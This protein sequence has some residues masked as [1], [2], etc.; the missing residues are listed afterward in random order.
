MILIS[1]LWDRE[2]MPWQADWY[3]Q[4]IDQNFGASADQH[5][6]LWYTDY[7]QHGDEYAIEDPTRTVSYGGELQEALRALAAWVEQGTPPPAST[8]YRIA[9]GQVIIPPTAA[10]RKGIQPVVDLQVNG[11]DRADIAVGQTVT[12]TGTI[13]AAPGDGEVVSAA[14]DFDGAGTFPESSG[15]KD[16][17]NR[18]TVTISHRFDKPG[19]YFPTLLGTTQPQSAVGTPYARLQN[20]GRVRVVVK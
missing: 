3:R 2:A 8:S 15:V 17:V 11:H 5:V 20:L 7:A 14:W 10:E 12:F 13:A 16:G 18:A 9:D 19:T 4:R 1:S 6:R